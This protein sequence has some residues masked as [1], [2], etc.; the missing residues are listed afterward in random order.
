MLR[1]L[2][3]VFRAQARAGYADRVIVVIDQDDDSCYALK[4]R[5]HDIAVSVG[6]I[7]AG[8]P[9]A[10]TRLRIR[11]ATT[12][13]ESWFIGDPAAVRA[14]YP[15]LSGTRP[16][17]EPSPAPGHDGAGLGVAAPPA[18][19]PRLLRR[20]HA[21]SRGRPRDRSASRPQPRRECVA[22][23]SAI[24]AHPTRDLWT[25]V[26][27]WSP[28]R[29]VKLAPNRASARGASADPPRCPPSAPQGDPR[30]GHRQPVPQVGSP[31]LWLRLAQ[32][33]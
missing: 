13:L 30:V 14:A 2:P 3:G 33:G 8:Q 6:L 7:Y 19:E 27:A 12:E 15:R 22:Q 18:G 21:E 5:I 23:L 20:P 31:Q 17:I 28:Y 29:L 9:T 24:P 4:Q 10:T 16:A 32:V 11:I 25:R 1:R 26:K